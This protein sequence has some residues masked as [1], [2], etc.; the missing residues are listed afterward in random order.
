MFARVL[1]RWDSRFGSCF[2]RLP[3]SHYPRTVKLRFEHLWPKQQP[4][5]TTQK[6][7]Q[8]GMSKLIHSRSFLLFI[9]SLFLSFDYSPFKIYLSSSIQFSLYI[10]LFPSFSFFPFFSHFSTNSLSISPSFNFFGWFFNFNFPLVHFLRPR[11]DTHYAYFWVFA[12]SHN[13]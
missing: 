8:L 4:L 7:S 13:F 5:H 1:C 6:Q 2:I 12:F 11:P 3:R 10:T 9:I